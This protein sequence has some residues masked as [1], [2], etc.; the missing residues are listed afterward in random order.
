MTLPQEIINEF[1]VFITNKLK[2]AYTE[3]TF[4]DE[5]FDN[6]TSIEQ[7][8]L[9]QLLEHDIEVR[10]KNKCKCKSDFP[11]IPEVSFKKGIWK[12]KYKDGREY[13]STNAVHWDKLS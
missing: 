2:T 8:E 9:S 3:S 12:M 10:L 6:Y 11:E 7:I 1:L 13:V 5:F 4:L